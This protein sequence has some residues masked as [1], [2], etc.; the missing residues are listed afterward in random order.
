MDFKGLIKDIVK[1]ETQ[2]Q[3]RFKIG[4]V[5][6]IDDKPTIIFSGEEN[7]SEKGYS[8]LGSYTPTVG[9]RVLLV[10]VKSTYVILD[11]LIV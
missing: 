8:Y 4:T 10:R 11:K 5:A 1:E 6:N 9:D 7:P 2:K 3:A